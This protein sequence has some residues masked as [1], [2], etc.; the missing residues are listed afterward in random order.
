MT[1][2]E[3]RP[4]AAELRTLLD[5]YEE[6]ALALFTA[7]ESGA[8]LDSSVATTLSGSTTQQQ[9]SSG[10]PQQRDGHDL[11]T[12]IARLHDYDAKFNDK[13]HSTAL[14]HVLQQHR[15]DALVQVQQNRD[16]ARK[17]QIER[18]SAMK[19]ELDRMVKRGREER[20]AAEKA[21][22]E[23]LPYRHVLNYAS[24]LSRITSAPPG[25]RPPG[26]AAKEEEGT[27]SQ[28]QQQ[29][30]QQQHIDWPFPS[31]AQMRRGALAAAAAAATTSGPSDDA[32]P[33]TQEGATTASTGADAVA[34]AAGGIQ[35]QQPAQ[36][37]S[38]AQQA[39]MHHYAAQ[40]PVDNEDAFDLDLN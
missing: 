21:E 5:Q 20:R 28:Q 18:L 1:T 12:L 38:F 2:N 33:R 11:Q 9:P 23:P 24:Y 32:A 22:A 34:A 30:Q 3:A 40:E 27:S 16:T 14:Q 15:I 26:S 39:H 19:A 17:A 35:L 13:L 4:L 7:I 10:L 25:Y 8:G 6:C 36:Q 37:Q 29:Q 31:E